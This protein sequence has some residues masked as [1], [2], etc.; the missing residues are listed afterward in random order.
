MVGSSSGIISIHTGQCGL[1]LGGELWKRLI[2]EQKT[3]VEL[4]KDGVG[5]G[6]DLMKEVFFHQSSNGHYTPRALLLDLEPRVIDSLT[7]SRLFEKAQAHK[8]NEGTGN[9]WTSGYR[10][11]RDH[12][13]TIENMIQHEVERADSFQGF[14][15]C[16]SIAGGTGSGLGSYLLETLN[17]EYSQKIIQTYSVF[18][19]M[20]NSDVVVSPYNATLALKWLIGGANTVVIL[21]NSELKINDGD[22]NDKFA[23][24][25]AG[26]T[27]PLRFKGPDSDMISMISNLTPSVSN[28]HFLSTSL[29]Q[30]QGQGRTHNISSP[31][32]YISMLK[33]IQGNKMG[34][35]LDVVRQQSYEGAIN[36]VPRMKPRSI[37]VVSVPLIAPPASN[38]INSFAL[39]NHTGIARSLDKLLNQCDRLTRKQDKGA[40]FWSYKKDWEA[41]LR[42]GGND[43]GDELTEAKEE[44]KKVVNEYREMEQITLS[45]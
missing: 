44:V 33:I 7:K 14:L 2:E 11:G 32:C 18:P 45:E 25:M 41:M 10:Q 24:V 35:T 16:H 13:E 3:A 8:G 38:T 26:T 40:F 9:I 22:W 28:C 21:D 31:S 19:D 4:T 36:F 20:E 30:A 37:K 27:S 5:S 42:D 6:D 1:Q 29:S 39:V 23:N 43:I 17:D 34:A 15:L 12:S